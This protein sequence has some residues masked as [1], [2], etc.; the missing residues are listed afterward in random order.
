[1]SNETEPSLP[2]DIPEQPE[3][4]AGQKIG[5]ARVSSKDQNLDRQLAALK[6]E[7][8]FR[9][10]TDTVSGSSTQR[11]VSMGRLIMCV[12]AINSLW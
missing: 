10:F 4:V 1:M 7:K 3:A 12:P 6:K 11:P 2:L 9:I 5:Y 8:V